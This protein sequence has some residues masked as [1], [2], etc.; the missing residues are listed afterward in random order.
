[1]K[2]RNDEGYRYVRQVSWEPRWTCWERENGRMKRRPDARTEE[3]M[4]RFLGFRGEE[5]QRHLA[6]RNAA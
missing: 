2:G 5:L 3:E 1:M 6:I 4:L